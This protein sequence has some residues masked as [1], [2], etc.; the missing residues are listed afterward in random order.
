MLRDNRPVGVWHLGKTGEHGNTLVV[1]AFQGA[2]FAAQGRIDRQAP[3][4]DLTDA[5]IVR[6]IQQPPITVGDERK[7]PFVMEVTADDR[8]KGAL[9][10]QV[11]RAADD[12][13]ERP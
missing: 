2:T 9:L 12:A 1:R 13:E 6:V 11:D 3:A 10:E 5:L 4:Q 8:M 7:G